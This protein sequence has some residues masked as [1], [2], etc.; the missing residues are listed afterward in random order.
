MSKSGATNAGVTGLTS[1]EVEQRVREGRVNVAPDPNRRTLSQILRTNVF[2]IVNLIM[3][4][5]FALI[6]IAGYPQD[7]LFVG[8]VV[9]N[10]VI[11]VAQ[12]L[13]ARRELQRL[14][15]VAAAD[16]I[17]VRDGQELTIGVDAVVADDVLKLLAGEQAVVD[18]EVLAS[19]GLAMDES[20][21]TG[22]SHTIK[23]VAG[24]EIMSG[25][26][27]AAGTG[28]VRATGVGADSYANRLRAEA[29]AFHP[30]ESMLRRSVNRILRWLTI[31]IPIASGLLLVSLLQ[32]QSRWQD[33]L[34]GT[35]AASVAMVP[36]GLVLLTS[37]AFV[38]G[39]LELSRRK[40]LAKQLTTVETLARV[41]VLCLD[42]TG[43]ITTGEIEFARLHPVDGIDSE[44]SWAA[45]A[46]LAAA[47][48][49]PNA[50]MGAISGRVGPSPDWVL[51][52]WEPFSSA[53]KWSGGQFGEHGWFYIGAPDVLLDVEQHT[54][55]LQRVDVLNMAGQRIIAL[56][57]S[58]TA[59]E[60][61]HAPSD[62]VV[63]GLIEL[64][65]QLRPNVQEILGYF[66]AQDVTI[67][68]ISGDNPDTVSAIAVRAGVQNGSLALDARQLPEDQSAL[69][70]ALRRTT[71]FGRVKPH[72]KKA[73]VNALQSEGHVVAMTGDGVNDVLALKDADLGIAMGSGSEASRTVADLVLVD[74]SFATLP[75]VLGE[76]RKVINNVERV[77]NLFMTKAVY[78]VLLTF[79]VGVS[80]VPFPF[81]PRQLSL[82]GTFSIGIPG[83][84]LALNPEIS[85][86]RGGFLRRILLFSIPAGIVA[87]ATTFAVYQYGR[88]SAGLLLVE[89]RTLATFTLLGIGLAVLIV[90][91]RPLRLWKVMIAVAMAT[92]YLA[93]ASVP[94]LRLYFQLLLFDDPRTWAVGF[95]ATV[96]ASVIIAFIP[97][98]TV[99]FHERES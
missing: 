63:L 93:I 13:K 42:K 69:A 18:G 58:A 46:A 26:F 1:A 40:A 30:T 59:P 67:K 70:D 45:L 6:L 37:L 25:S 60:D 10:S 21:L 97:R 7:G 27:V 15:V 79:L 91:A 76:G 77:A 98:I 44:L 51:T 50:T 61:D 22:E 19:S 88:T 73:M 35:V 23:K 17:V 2:T 66:A 90:S 4:T 53:R 24:D 28:L 71:V 56:A 3:L 65:D 81:L 92:A 72:Q 75:V 52:S 20:L 87:G 78:A 11:G 36:D 62:L 39:V 64:E 80:G 43:T 95:T 54:A 47:D 83:L 38:A 16:T 55:E 41:D 49:S 32:S 31:I 9:A 89:A 82:I 99:R 86:V 84:L 8:V 57:A 34:Q 48:D 12:E 68:V 96:V 14:A 74:N 85:R 94:I 5:L 29:Q 33:A